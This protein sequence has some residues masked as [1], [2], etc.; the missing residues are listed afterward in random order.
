MGR[1]SKWIEGQP[2]DS[3]EQVA[4][5]A[6][7][8][9]LERM[10]HYLERAVREPKSEAENVHQLRVF[11]RRAAAALEIFSAWLPSRRGQWMSKQVKRVRKAGGAARDLDVLR[12]RWS[13]RR[14]RMSSGPAAL[15]LEQVQH[16]RREA[17]RPIEE[18][19]SKLVEKRF[20]RRTSRFLKRV[21]TQDGQPSD[22][23]PFG[24]MARV[25]LGRLVVPYLAAARAEMGDA[26]AL[27]AFRIQGK[28]VRYAME[29][30]AG[31]FNAEFR[32]ELYPVVARLQ[33]RLGAI[34]DHVTAQ[35]YL[36]GWRD[37]IDSCAIR[38][39]LEMG[40]Q[41]ERHC[42]DLSRQEFLAWWTSERREDLRQR[43]AQHVQLESPNEQPSHFEDYG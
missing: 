35:T 1:N 17:Q 23:E 8:A 38:D 34:N 43:F 4:R 7:A 31:A 30:F 18:V 37:K 20:V 21:R 36:A 14:E 28:Q 33:D 5:R 27:H 11:A 39:A 16:C 26:E 12:I 13:D 19:Y 32:Q 3:T 41:H 6:L 10:W 9:R 29:I 42:F 22:R 24:C 2:D 40:M 25:A 15:L